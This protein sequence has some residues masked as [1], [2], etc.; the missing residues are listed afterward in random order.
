MNESDLFS[1]DRANSGKYQESIVRATVNENKQIS[2]PNSKLIDILPYKT[3]RKKTRKRKHFNN[4][5]HE[6]SFNEQEIK[7]NASSIRSIITVFN[8]SIL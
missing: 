2:E 6:P 8:K 1:K 5:K 4:D 7:E 3:S